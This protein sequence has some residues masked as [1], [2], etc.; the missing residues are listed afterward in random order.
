MQRY[1]AIVKFFTVQDSVFFLAHSKFTLCIEFLFWIKAPNKFIYTEKEWKKGE[2]NGYCCNVEELR[3]VFKVK[4]QQ[5]QQQPC[6]E[7]LMLTLS[8]ISSDEMKNVVVHIFVC[9]VLSFFSC[10]RTLSH[11]LFISTQ[12]QIPFAPLKLYSMKY[13]NRKT[14]TRAKRKDK[15]PTNR[16]K[17]WMPGEKK[18]NENKINRRDETQLTGRRWREGEGNSGKIRQW[19]CTLWTMLP[20]Q[21][22]RNIASEMFKRRMKKKELKE[23]SKPKSH[24]RQ[25]FVMLI[26]MPA[27]RVYNSF[28]CATKIC[29]KDGGGRANGIAQ[30]AW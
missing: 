7:T 18:I 25:S 27:F 29:L 10:Y 24:W 9:M 12:F 21:C 15:K 22:R 19:I 1:T 3:A 16:T 28:G 23:I 11:S 20:E 13:A 17:H 4:Q 14:W 6:W 30:C 26:I 2:R 8:G 5:Q